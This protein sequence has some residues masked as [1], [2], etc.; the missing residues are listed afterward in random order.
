MS[1]TSDRKISDI[2]SDF[3]GAS[4]RATVRLFKSIPSRI[5]GRIR[6]VWRDYRDRPPRKDISR[7]Y[8]VVGYTTKKYVEERYNAERRMMIMRRGLL[9]MIFFLL[10]FIVLDRSLSAFNYGEIKQMFGFSSW[11]ELLKNDPFS[12]RKETAPT[13][14]VQPTAVSTTA[15]N[16]TKT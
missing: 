4:W 13:A 5:F 12:E 15:E 6:K 16:K 10:L 9:A 3:L 7:V 1:R 2:M 11:T 8:L 14:P